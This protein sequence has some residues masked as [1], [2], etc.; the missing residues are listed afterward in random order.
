MAF[1]T[2]SSVSSL[3]VQLLVRSLTLP[4]TVLRLQGRDISA[5]SGG[6][7]TIRVPLPREAQVQTTP[8]AE[9]TPI[10][11][12][13]DEAELSVVHVFDASRITDEDLTLSI[14]DFGRQVLAPQVAA[15]ATRAEDELS[16]E[17]N[18]LPAD[19]SFPA[20][21]A[22]L[23]DEEWRRD[24]EDRVLEAGEILDDSDVPSDSRFFAVSASVARRLLRID[25]FTASNQRGDGGSALE[26]ATLGRL[27]GFE[28]V[29]S[30][31]LT[32]GEAAAYH[33]SAF[34]FAMLPPMAPSSG[35]SATATEQSLSVRWVRQWNPSRLSEESVVSVFAGATA[36]DLDR[37]VKL[38][39]AAP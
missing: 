8:G 9:V 36:I 39:T 16:D 28:F 10:D 38:D 13:E 12:D 18:D 37:V 1:V 22:T 7:T 25:K 15:V 11:I 26:G 34:G 3:A 20:D 30:T 5:P 14:E 33:R 6:T 24:M 4:R 23:D 19:L 29:K 31:G 17:L 27:G 21:P 35:T 2:A 32:A